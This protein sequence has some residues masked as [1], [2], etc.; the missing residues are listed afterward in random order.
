M[1]TIYILATARFPGAI[2]LAFE[3]QTCA[4]IQ[5]AWYRRAGV[6]AQ[7]VPVELHE[8]IRCATRDSCPHLAEPG[9]R[10]SEFESNHAAH[11]PA[12]LEAGKR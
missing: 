4:D 2:R 10:L 12:R 6:Q 8:S 11:I 9:K 1:K 3:C 7:V 5:V